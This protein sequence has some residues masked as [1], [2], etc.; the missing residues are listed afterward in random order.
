MRT[1]HDE[2]LLN[3]ALE[4]LEARLRRIETMIEKVRLALQRQ[5]ASPPPVTWTT[6][7][8]RRHSQ[9]MRAVWKQRRKKGR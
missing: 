7:Q 5:R 4:G 1:Q 8:R 2:L 9:R 6:A 3:A